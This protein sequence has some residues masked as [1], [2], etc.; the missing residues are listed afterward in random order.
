MLLNLTWSGGKLQEAS[1]LVDREVLAPRKVNVL[2]AGD[3]VDSFTTAKG[4][5]RN[6]K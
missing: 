3:V 4:L 5:R 2:H 6:I 1:L